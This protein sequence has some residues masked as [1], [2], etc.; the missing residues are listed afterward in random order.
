MIMVHSRK[1]SLPLNDGEN[2]IFI[3]S[4]WYAKY[5][6]MMVQDGTTQYKILRY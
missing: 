1:F 2:F 4:V 6:Y 3:G 5:K